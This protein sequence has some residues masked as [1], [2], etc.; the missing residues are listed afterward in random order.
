M[1][2]IKRE[3]VPTYNNVFKVIEGG[4]VGYYYVDKNTA[5]HIWG[6]EIDVSDLTYERLAQ[7]HTPI[8]LSKTTVGNIDTQG[9][10]LVEDITELYEI[11]PSGVS[12]CRVQNELDM[13]LVFGDDFRIPI[14][15]YESSQLDAPILIIDTTKFDY[16]DILELLTGGE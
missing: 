6:D 12:I 2:N 10:K 14:R 1:I 8:V 9:N 16:W 7:V 11:E 5:F 4:K 13:F 15:M 3:Y